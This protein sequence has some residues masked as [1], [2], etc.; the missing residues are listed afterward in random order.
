M[1]HEKKSVKKIRFAFRDYKNFAPVLF[2]VSAAMVL[3]ISVNSNM[4]MNQTII[5]LEEATQQR[6]LNAAIAASLYVPAEELD[7]YHTPEDTRVPEYDELRDRLIKFAEKFNVLYVYYWRDYG[8]GRIQYIVDNDLDS[9]T[10]MTP[11][12]FFELNDAAQK[13]LSGEMSFT[14]LAEYTPVWDGLLSAFAP[15]YDKAGNLYCI[16][17]VDIS[18]EIIL[19]QRDDTNLLNTIRLVAILVSIITTGVSMYLYSAAVRKS[20]LA[21][22]AKSSFLAN[23]SHEIRTPMNAVIGMTELLLR[24]DLPQAA[25]ENLSTI[26]QAGTNLLSIINDI[27]D[28]SK[29]EAGK[30]EILEGE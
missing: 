9:E 18:D 2:V 22:S 19:I 28:F 27:L 25:K 3:L 13:T 8:D 4:V 21:N 14:R 1:K 20:R 11:A 30:L 12:N 10:Q 29:I 16:A 7:R 17:G 15:V 6:L 23:M 5:M 24:Q 26:K